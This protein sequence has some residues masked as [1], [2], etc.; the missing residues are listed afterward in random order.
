MQREANGIKPL[1]ADSERLAAGGLIALAIAEDLGAQ[2]DITASALIDER[3]QG[4]VQLV[5]RGAGVL[6]GMPIVQMVF[7]RLDRNVRFQGLIEDGSPVE[8]GAIVAELSGPLRALLIGE[9]TALNFVSH[10]SG[11]ATRTREFVDAIA[12]TSATILDTRKTLP[13]YRVLQKYAVRAGGG[14]NHRMGL[15]DG[16]LIKDNHLAA[17]QS[18]GKQGGIA[19]AIR[20]ARDSV[21]TSVPVEVEVDSLE[22]LRDALRDSPDI[23]LLDNMSPPMLVEAIAI[24]NQAAP[25]VLLEASGGVSLQNVAEI[26]RT[27]VE[28]ISIGALTHSAP[29]LDMA[30]DW[31][32]QDTAGEPAGGQHVS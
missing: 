27:G 11:I 28:R 10:L 21:P 1:F 3:E 5:A 23:V 18:A 32:R 2:G 13:G 31:K 8:A 20:E 25:H 16:C 14:S 19:A 24:R 26:A 15:F 22:Q 6:A 4:S 12:G 9:R 7:E 17:W 30:F 29:A